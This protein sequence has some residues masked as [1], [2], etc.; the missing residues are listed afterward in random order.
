MKKLYLFFVLLSGFNFYSLAQYNFPFFYPDIPLE[1][2]VNDL[3]FRLSVQEKIDQLLYEDPAIE[4][5]RI[6]K[7]NWWNECL[8]GVGRS[9]YATVFTQSIVVSC[10]KKLI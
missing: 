8:H 7:Y 2:R 4:M 1:E 10:D 5:L 6:P 3:V 9:G